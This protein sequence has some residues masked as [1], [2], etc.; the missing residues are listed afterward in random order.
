MRNQE[1]VAQTATSIIVAVV[2]AVI[3]L[4]SGQAHAWIP[5][6]LAFVGIAVLGVAVARALRTVE[7]RLTRLE[8]R[9]SE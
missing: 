2:F 8:Q 3:G 9:H 7:D 5:A 6:G 1:I 4:V